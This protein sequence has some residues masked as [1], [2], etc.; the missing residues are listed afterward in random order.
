MFS[1]KWR[2]RSERKK[3][4][5]F[6]ASLSGT[7]ANSTTCKRYGKIGANMRRFASSGSRSDR[8]WDQSGAEVEDGRE[9]LAE[10]AGCTEVVWLARELPL[11]S[12]EGRLERADTII[13]LVSLHLE[14]MNAYSVTGNDKRA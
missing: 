2:E 13:P 1:F 10:R 14:R 3:K 6:A 9:G 5:G 7:L 8:L 12:C 11:S 4:R